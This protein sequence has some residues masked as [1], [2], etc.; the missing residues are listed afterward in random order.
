[1]RFSQLVLD[2]PMIQEID[3]NPLLAS[4]EG[5]LALDARVVLFSQTTDLATDSETD[6]PVY[7]SNYV[8]TLQLKDGTT[9]TIRPIRP[10]DEPAMVRFHSTLSDESVYRRFFS[11]MKL[12]SRTRHERLTRVCFIDYDREMALVAENPKTDDSA[13]GD[14]RASGDW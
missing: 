6:D 11:Q 12:E 5:L 3:I 1:M 10:E 7:P 9:L 13:R 8:E 14:R 4:A 2:L